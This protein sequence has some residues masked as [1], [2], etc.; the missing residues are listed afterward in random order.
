MTVL[1]AATA[2]LI[3]GHWIGYAR[4]LSRH[5]ELAERQRSGVRLWLAQPVLAVAIA[6]MWTVHPRRTL[7]NVR[8][9]REAPRRSPAVRIP[10]A[11]ELKESA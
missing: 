7:R 9:W 10:G 8:S 6:W 4:L 5:F 2:A 3:V 11:P 1:L